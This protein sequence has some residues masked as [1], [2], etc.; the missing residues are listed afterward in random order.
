MGRKHIGATTRSRDVIDHVGRS[1]RHMPFSVGEPLEP[2]LS[3]FST[4]FSKYSALNPTRTHTHTHTEKERHTSRVI[5]L[6]D[7]TNGHACA[8][9][10]LPS[11]AVAVVVC[12]VVCKVAI[13]KWCVP[14]QKFTI[15]SL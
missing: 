13:Y 10:L 1:I 8:T 6:A 5:L 7:R 15:G 14:E 2:S 12:N 11:V 4:A 9:V 3:L